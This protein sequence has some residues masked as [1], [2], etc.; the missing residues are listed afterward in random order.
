M[1][2]GISRSLA[3]TEFTTITVFNHHKIMKFADQ[4]NSLQTSCSCLLASFTVMENRKLYVKAAKRV[5]EI[6][7]HEENYTTDNIK[8]GKLHK[9]LAKSS[10]TMQV[11][12]IHK[13]KHAHKIIR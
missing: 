7:E 5:A 9:L 1:V 2:G 13:M 10:N 11:C 8:V 3:I 12:N 4:D 6:S